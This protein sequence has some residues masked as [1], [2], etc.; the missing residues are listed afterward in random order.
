[1]EDWELGKQRN[2]KQQ[3][4]TVTRKELYSV[5]SDKP[6]EKELEKKISMCITESHCC[7]AELNATMKISHISI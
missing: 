2:E 4:P 3:S 7:A 6:H 5:F 1:M